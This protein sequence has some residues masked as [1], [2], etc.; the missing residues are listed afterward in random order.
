MT[1]HEQ[2]MEQAAMDAVRE[3][4]SGWG[5]RLSTTVVKLTDGYYDKTLQDVIFQHHWRTKI[6]LDVA[7]AF[8]I[9]HEAIFNGDVVFVRIPVGT[10]PSS[11]SSTERNNGA[12][13]KIS[14]PFKARFSGG[15]GDQDGS[16]SWS[17]PIDAV[18][19]ATPKLDTV[20]VPPG[21]APLEVGTTKASRT[22][23]HLAQERCLARWPYGLDRI[24]LLVV[25]NKKLWRSQL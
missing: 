19:A 18:S 15:P 5:A 3:D 7:Y 22:W 17:A 12:L 11:D 24:V 9:I 16:L 20:V 21:S 23:L 2:A 8:T 10:V 14:A 1:V 4:P 6:T 13:Q 25:L